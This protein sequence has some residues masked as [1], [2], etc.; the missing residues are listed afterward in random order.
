MPVPVPC[1]AVVKVLGGG[2]GVM[3]G[4][5]VFRKG[6][7]MVAEGMGRP[8]PVPVPLWAVTEVETARMLTR[9]AK[10]VSGAMAME[11]A[12]VAGEVCR[13]R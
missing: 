1:G 9:V 8:V 4:R 13:I 7:P 6:A 3:E 10:R 5:V 2:P 11:I 12:T